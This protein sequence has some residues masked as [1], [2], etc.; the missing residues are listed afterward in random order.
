LRYALTGGEAVKIVRDR[1]GMIKVDNRVR[2]DPRFP[3][4]IMDVVSIERTNEH[5]R[6]LLDTKGRYH[7]HRI[8]AKEAQFKLCKVI[9]KK[10][11]KNKI[12]Y[13]T[14]HDGRTIRFPHPDIDINDTVKINL[15]SKE[16]T[17]V[18]KFNNNA[19]AFIIGGNN[20]GRIGTLQSLEKHPGSFEI[21]HIKD[22]RN[23]I[24]ATRLG[25]VI[26]IGDGK[27]PAIDLP[28]GE[29]VRVTLQEERRKRVGDDDEEVDEADEE[30]SD[31]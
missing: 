13:I 17:S 9:Q 19:T 22:K 27:D 25:N 21:A 20:I 10:I 18:I 30:E 7:P 14:T 29:G 8:D 6:I 15:Q 26:I 3:L 24:F 5:F 12:P 1:E 2:R 31:N 11:G 23:N 28:K 4:G 16:I